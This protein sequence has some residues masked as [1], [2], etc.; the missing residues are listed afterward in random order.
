MAR[1]KLAGLRILIT[2]ASQ[3]I[4]RALAVAAAQRGA[5][6][7]ASARSAELLAEL[8]G[9]VRTTGGVLEAVVADVTSPTDRQRMVETARN[10]FGGID[11]LIN[12]AGVGATGHFVEAGPER[13]RTMMEVNFFGLT[14][15][16]RAFL[17]QLLKG[18]TPAI[19]NISSVA[20]KRALPARSEYSASKYAVQGFSEALRAE[21]A[22]DAIDVIVVNPGLTQ[23]NF[24]RNMIEQKALV[25][26][27]HM[28]GMTSEEV[29]LATLK[30]LERGSHEVTL[31]LM[32]RFIVFMSRFFPWLTDWVIRGKVR[33]L[34]REEMA[35]RNEAKKRGETLPIASA[36][37]QPV[38]IRH[39]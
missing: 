32:G 6:V 29:A 25:A 34:F 31:G 37:S 8:A 23:T 12:N 36:V 18:T 10:A 4:G 9:E 24:S 27:D 17:P 26:M 11:V 38:V 21:L 7:L 14:E 19:V 20:G 2:G 13:L 33:K 35:A 22:K 30:A 16:T 3:G 28:R 39:S 1:R 5:K 15:T